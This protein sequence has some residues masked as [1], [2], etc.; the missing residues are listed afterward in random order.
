M[1]PTI[2]INER[3]SVVSTYKLNSNGKT[4]FMPLK[5]KYKTEEITFT[6]LALKHPTSKGQRMIHVF[7]MSDGQ[8]DYRLEFDAERLSWIYCSMIQGVKQ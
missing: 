3:V 8:N 4:C 6:K 2:D 5:M 1:N 7:D